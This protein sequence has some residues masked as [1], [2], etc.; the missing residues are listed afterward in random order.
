MNIKPFKIDVTDADL[1][2]LK[3]RLK[4]TRFPHEIKDQGWKRGM[5]LGVTK[6]LVKRWADSYDWRE[7]EATLNKF[8][9][10]ITEVEGQPIH[11]MHVRSKEANATP[12]MLVHGYPGSFVDFSKMIEPLTDPVA[13]GGKATDAFDVMVPSLPGFGFSTPVTEAG[14]DIGRVARAFHAIMQELGYAK[15]AV[16]G[17]DVGAGVCEEL[18]IL[19]GEQIIGSLIATDPGAIATEYTP[20]TDHLTEAEKAHHQELKAARVEDFGYIQIQTTRPQTISYSLTDSPVGQM[21]WIVEKF[22]EWTDP[23]KEELD[24]KVDIDQLLTNVTVYWFGYGGEGGANLL[25]EA[26]HAAAAWG[27]GHSV[28]Q[29]FVSFGKEP[30]VR[31]ILDPNG[32]IAHWSEFPHGGHFPS[33]EAPMDLVG[34]L[35]KFFG[36]LAK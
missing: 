4:A 18:C 27:R 15:Y 1:K 34:D 25:Y 20:S 19:G 24:D 9:Q 12:L 29:G 21:T 22:K 28:T 3:A 32:K 11:F 23:K 5:P 14:W 13:H 31:R 17:S 10:F 26:A 6:K 8:P 36:N 2:D 7:Q 35:R 30:L 16:H 33:Y